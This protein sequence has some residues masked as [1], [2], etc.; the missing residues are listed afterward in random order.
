MRL[1]C[2]ACLA[3]GLEFISFFTAQNRF[4]SNFPYKTTFLIESGAL[5]QLAIN[6]SGVNVVVVVVVVV[7]VVVLEI[8][9]CSLL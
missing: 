4:F 8:S 7:D 6:T 9:S 1:I 3:H 5:N 2:P